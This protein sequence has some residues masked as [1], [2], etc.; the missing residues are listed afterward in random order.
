M[1][2]DSGPSLRGPALAGLGEF[3][4]EIFNEGFH[5]RL[6]VQHPC[7]RLRGYERAAPHHHHCGERRW[8]NLGEHL[9][10]ALDAEQES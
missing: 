1:L 9:G 5:V 2:A 4:V 8:R 7:A 3:G 10:T 6:T